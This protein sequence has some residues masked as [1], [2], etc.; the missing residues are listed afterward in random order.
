MTI[1]KNHG[2]RRRKRRRRLLKKRKNA[3]KA[4]KNVHTYI[5]P[6]QQGL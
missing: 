4:Y 6:T 1:Y 3:K 2:K 5:L